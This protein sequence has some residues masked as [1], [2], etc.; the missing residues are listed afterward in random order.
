ME[1]STWRDA[2]PSPW[3]AR[4]GN[5]SL[6]Q[7]WTL[8][9]L[10]L[11]VSWL[12]IG[13]Q[14]SL[15]LWINCLLLQIPTKGCSKQSCR[16]RRQVT[17]NRLFAFKFLFSVIS[18]LHYWNN[19]DIRGMMQQQGRQKQ[20]KAKE[21]MSCLCRKKEKWAG[22]KEEF[23]N[24]LIKRQIAIPCPHN[25]SESSL[26]HEGHP[27]SQQTKNK[28]PQ[29]TSIT[30][31][32]HFHFLFW[33]REIPQVIWPLLKLH[34]EEEQQQLTSAGRSLAVQK[35]PMCEP[36][37]RAAQGCAAV[38]THSKVSCEYPAQPDHLLHNSPVLCSPVD[39][40]LLVS[41]HASRA[42]L[43]RSCFLACCF[44]KRCWKQLSPRRGGS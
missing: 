42:D 23:T 37:L 29:I 20:V 28:P 18:W 1:I 40:S 3:G 36:E 19:N 8:T 33:E 30:W 34:Q 31:S 10:S 2:Q 14:Q 7:R 21:T 39:L 16:H 25:H 11:Q 38:L 15:I 32:G 22:S 41:K 27:K 9:H 17:R 24:Y 4:A 43:L 26:T 35:P 12:I 13:T 6:L 5:A 44:L